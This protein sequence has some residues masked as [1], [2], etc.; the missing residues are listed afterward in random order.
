MKTAAAVTLAWVCVSQIPLTHAAR[1]NQTPM[2]HVVELLLDLSIRVE[3]DGRT[4][5]KAY[6]K[7]ACWCEETLARK[8]VEIAEEKEQIK[9]TQTLIQEL[10]GDLGALGASIEALK[11]NIAENLESQREAADLRDKEFGEYNEEKL[12]TEE[13]IGGLEAAI[14]V[15]TG[16]GTGKKGFLE[17]F[18]EAQVLGV[19]A[20]LRKVLRNTIAEQAVSSSEFQAVKSFVDHPDGFAGSRSVS[21]VQIANNPFGDYAPQSSQIQGILKGMYEAFTTSLEKANGEE[22]DKQKAFEELMATNNKELETMELSLE[23]E[24]LDQSDK[25]KKLADAKVDLDD[26]KAQLNADE[27]FFAETKTSCK[28]KAQE[29]SER[30]RLRTEELNGIRMGIKLLSSEISEA[31]FSR[32][33][34]SLL[35]LTSGRLGRSLAYGKLRSLARSMDARVLIQLAAKVRTGGALDDVVK[36]LD[37][38][39]A[40]FRKE[41][42]EDIAHRDRCQ[43]AEGKNK[44]DMEDAVHEIVKSKKAIARMENQVKSLKTNINDL[45]SDIAESEKEMSTQLDLRNKEVADFKQ[46]LKDDVDAIQILSETIDVLSK[47]YKKNKIPISLQ[48]NADPEREYT[49]DPDKAPDTTWKGGGYGGRKGETTGILAIIRMLIEDLQHEMTNARKEDAEA[50]VSFEKGRA[51]AQ[52]ML[53][54]QVAKKTSKEEKLAELEETIYDTQEHQSQSASDLE[55]EKD[56][57]GSLMKDC[58]WVESHFRTRAGKREAEIEGLQE[59][60]GYLAGV[61]SGEELAP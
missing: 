42:M 50:E 37:S 1:L 17:V 52:E 12:E 7:Y 19:V 25:R 43:N 48:Q 3:I 56:F 11:K 54:A 33:T 5:Q 35:Q 60:K 53:D 32:A 59:A 24:E 49:K 45:E 51:A 55:G 39:I 57:K 15:L 36:S 4:E 9:A 20:G 27:F 23:K 44:N 61:E 2:S 40:M 30:S 31:V 29:W 14:R 8:A 16:A 22:A 34:T 28:I 58:A 26:T 6:D 21:A 41:G 46:S 47:F 10:M 13:C 38:M 18:Q